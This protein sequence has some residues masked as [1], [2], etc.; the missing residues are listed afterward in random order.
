MTDILVIQQNLE[1]NTAGLR[2][3]PSTA[4]KNA[5]NGEVVYT[6][7]QQ[8]DETASLID[9]LVQFIDNDALCDADPLVKVAIIHHQFEISHP[10]YDWNGR[11]GRIIRP[12][13]YCVKGNILDD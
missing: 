9:N 5:L 6:T 8:A 13:M 12:R 7:P 2:K 10:S 3:L 1:H 4:L 11:T